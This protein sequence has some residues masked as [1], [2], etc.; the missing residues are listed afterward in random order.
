MEELKEYCYTT[1]AEEEDVTDVCVSK[2]AFKLKSN[3]NCVFTLYNY[4]H[5]Y[6]FFFFF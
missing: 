4:I 5:V 6:Y 1:A 3:V 2:S